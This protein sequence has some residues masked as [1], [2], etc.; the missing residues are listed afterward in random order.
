MNHKWYDILV[1]EWIGFNFFIFRIHS[2]D[3]ND[4]KIKWSEYIG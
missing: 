4:K 3:M 1:I 2:I